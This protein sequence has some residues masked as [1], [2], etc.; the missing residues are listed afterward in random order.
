[1]RHNFD[2]STID[3]ISRASE[4]GNHHRK[5]II[6]IENNFDALV[7]LIDEK[8]LTGQFRLLRFSYNPAKE[9]KLIT[10]IVQD[11]ETKLQLLGC[12]FSLQ[13]LLMN[14]KA[15]DVLQLNLS[16]SKNRYDVFKTFLLQ[17]GNDFRL[18]SGA[19]MKTLL[20]I[21]LPKKNRPQ[22]VICGVG[23]R[24]DQ[25]DID[26]G[27]ID[28]SEQDRGRLTSA[29]GKL[30][31]EMLKYA[32]P[33]HFHLSEHVGTHGYSASIEEYHKLLD[34]EI[35]DFVMLSE[36]I[37]A[38][39]IFGKMNI[40]NQFKSEILDRYY[41][42]KNQDNKYHEGFLRGLLGEIRDLIMREP[43]ET[44]LGPKND[45]LRV[46]K[47]VIHSIKTWKVIKRN[48]SLEVLEV[49]MDQDRSNIEQYYRLYQSLTFL[50]TFRFLYQLFVV[51]EE[52]INL[53]E[54]NIYNNLKIVATKMGYERKIY[55]SASTQLIIHYQDHLK[56]AHIGVENLIK[57]IVEHL[58]KITLFYSMTHSVSH[59]G[60]KYKGNIAIDLITKSRFFKGIRFWDDILIAVD[61]QTALLNKFLSGFRSLSPKRQ[62]LLIE[63][64]IKW[65][66]LSPYTLIS[67]ITIIVKHKPSITD[68]KLIREFLLKFVCELKDTFEDIE[69]LCRV[70]N[71]YP[72]TMYNFI[73]LLPEGLLGRLIKVLSTPVW[74]V[75]IN[76]TREK[77]LSLC[78]LYN[79]SS[80]YFKRFIDKVFNTYPEYI[81]SFD[82]PK[83]LRQI[84][85]GLL[86]NIDNFKLTGERVN[87]LNNYYDFEFM[88]LGIN[89]IKGISYDIINKE[90]TIFSDNYIQVLFDLCREEVFKKLKSSFELSDLL[91]IYAAG[92]HARR[93]AFDDDCDLI[94]ILNSD[95]PELLFLANNIVMEMNKHIIKRSIMP[96]YRFA[97]RF[98]NYVT[99]FED[100]KN[101]F[102]KPDENVFIDKSQLLSA[103]MVVGSVQFETTFFKEII[104]PY[105]FDMKEEFIKSLIGEIR[106][107]YRYHSKSE[108]VDIK[109]SPG[110]LRH[111]ENFLFIL[112]A[113][114]NIRDSIS[115]ELFLKLLNKMPAFEPYFGKLMSNYNFLKQ[116]R[117]LYHLT[118]SNNDTL[119]KRYL[120][121]VLVP[122]RIPNNYKIDSE[123]K[124]YS[125]IRGAMA[126]NLNF[127]KS[128]IEYLYNFAI[129]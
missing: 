71:Y 4:L 109:E 80:I 20:D 87:K 61:S 123:D 82:E 124:L 115:D 101:L 96:H 43:L 84:S 72:K 103:R 45:G 100:L 13:F 66:Y 107:R 22:F 8:G 24:V 114:F 93:Q 69:K 25:D 126:E 2:Y 110:G 127:I 36:M 44:I 11:R 65:G 64:Y 17:T 99:T 14:L 73:S 94:I 1:L 91:A 59:D 50:E 77:F 35:Q 37:N 119:Q 53:E 29:L 105:I 120:R 86:R 28:E 76:L 12:Y 40:F 9:M 57:E 89:A 27:I 128:I 26:L 55:S 112:L 60:E 42:H 104:K 68:S 21:F 48:T 47:S 67:L 95:N 58:S 118:V 79:D 122:L 19:Y 23:T 56:I 10:Q 92:G 38:V 70:F 74:N 30:N 52:E 113:H 3:L 125:M 121:R 15:I 16:T 97:D 108:D 54:D 88:R 111:L 49:L 78:K 34:T 6:N 51:Q 83:K 63:A 90:F 75:E 46:I 62:K 98:R 102:E 32:C 116:V 85:E 18:L 106:S 7:S 33:L 81:K 117:D 5:H 41:Y 129:E 39:P 31:T